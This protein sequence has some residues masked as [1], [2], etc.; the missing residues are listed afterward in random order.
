MERLDDLEKS[1][2]D[3]TISRKEIKK[4]MKETFKARR[5]LILET[6]PP[7]DEILEKFPILKEPK[8]VN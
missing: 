3:D 6:S 2:Q 1:V 5:K 8:L 4:A 7:V